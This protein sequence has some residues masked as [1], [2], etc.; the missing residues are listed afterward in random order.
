MKKS[1]LVAAG[2][3]LALSSCTTVQH[4]ASTEQIDTRIYN[5][6][7]ADVNVSTEKQSHTFSWNW[8]PFRAFSLSSVKESAAAELLMEAKADVL[9]EPQYIVKR[10]GLFRGGEVTVIGYPATYTNFHHMTETDAALLRD[11]S[12]ERAHVLPMANIMSKFRKS[13]TP[14]APKAPK[15]PKFYD[16]SS[17][18]NQPH[19]QFISFHIGPNFGAYDC[20]ELEA[21]GCTYGLSYGSYGKKWGWYV[22][23]TLTSYSGETYDGNVGY[24]TDIHTTGQVTGGVIKTIGRNWNFMAG[25]GLGGYLSDV[26]HLYDSGDDI[27]SYFSIPL[28]AA[29]QWRSR[30]FNMSFGFNYATPVTSPRISEYCTD[31]NL[32]FLIG[33]GYSF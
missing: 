10:R 25:A 29:L 6:T 1:L 16:E 7:V 17:Y 27:K 32:S 3:A 11:A 2:A 19:K 15:A 13:N 23:G 21:Y 14:K 8:T 4:T 22:K 18:G 20:G 5:M 24:T 12:P 28:E 30:H 26:Y 31:G 33:I 9:V